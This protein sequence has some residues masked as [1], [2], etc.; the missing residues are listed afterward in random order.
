MAVD[1]GGSSRFA[2]GYCLDQLARDVQHGR[3]DAVICHLESGLSLAK[4][5]KCARLSVAVDFED[6]HSENDFA[7]SPGR[8]RLLRAVEQEA[9]VSAD[10]VTTTSAAMAE[11][12]SEAYGIAMPDVVYNSMPALPP[13]DATSNSPSYRLIWLSQTISL[14]RGLEELMVALEG[15]PQPW[16]LELRG[17]PT[18]SFLDWVRNR[19]SN[20]VAARIVLGGSVAP[21]CL[22]A[23]VSGA[24]IGL[25]L[26]LP[27]SR[28]KDLTAS[29]KIFHYMQNGLVVVATSTRG[30]S[31]IARQLP[32]VVRLVPPGDVLA[33]RQTITNL[34]IDLP[35]LHRGKS[36]RA[37]EANTL[38]G[39]E[40][41][42]SSLISNMERLIAFRGRRDG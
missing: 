12:L 35:Q 41:Y 26:E 37:Q 20:H 33:L 31:E 23:A 3:P 16:S 25:A 34:L 39:Y 1:G 30:Q 38:F 2:L 6:W 15:V 9:A 27:S 8:R 22:D 14:G 21:D 11:E 36:K 7:L 4:T 40:R 17:R 5:F 29:N 32:E 18:T 28:N 42:S 24:D 10:W 19:C 13:C